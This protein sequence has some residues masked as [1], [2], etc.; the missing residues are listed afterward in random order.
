[1]LKRSLRSAVDTLHKNVYT[2]LFAIEEKVDERI[3]SLEDDREV[4]NFQAR[5]LADRLARVEKRLDQRPALMSSGMQD[6]LR[7]ARQAQDEAERAHRRIDNLLKNQD[8]TD[9]AIEQMPETIATRLHEEFDIRAKTVDVDGEPLD[10]L[11][12]THP[13]WG[14]SVRGKIETGNDEA[15]GIE[16]PPEPEVATNTLTRTEHP[17]GCKNGE[18]C[19]L[20]NEDEYFADGKWYTVPDVS[21][22]LRRQDAQYLRYIAEKRFQFPLGIK[23]ALMMIA[24]RLDGDT[25]ATD[26][27]A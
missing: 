22:D 20:H 25:D 5:D 23:N 27:Y 7:M 13:K 2:D 11:P 15:V 4:R 17:M 9:A 24:E 10:I 12:P 21:A 14:Y 8:V 19:H 18:D 3:E 26:T 16:F 6:A 1:M